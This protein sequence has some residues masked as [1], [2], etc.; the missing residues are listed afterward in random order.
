MIQLHHQRPYSEHATY[1]VMVTENEY[2][3][4]RDGEV[5]KHGTVPSLVKAS[6]FI[7]E[8][9]AL[10]MAIDDIDHLIGMDE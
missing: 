2:V 6:V 8:K 1:Q 7:I 4:R 3:I 10:A 5:R 9:C